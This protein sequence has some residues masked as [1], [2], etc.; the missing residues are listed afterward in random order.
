MTIKSLTRV[1]LVAV[2]GLL[3]ATLP[4]ATT[5]TVRQA[6]IEKEGIELI[7][8]IEGVA[9]GVHYNTDALRAHA[10]NKMSKWT[11]NHHLSEIRLLINDGLR[12][13]LTRL[14]EI[15]AELPEWKQKSIDTMLVS[16]RALAADTN[17]AILKVNE[18]G[19]KPIVL[20]DEYRALL[21][22]MDEH[23][24]NLVR[25]ADAA[26]DYAAAHHQATEAGLEVPKHR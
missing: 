24:E 7:N 19:S 25:T 8:Q 5:T 1:S 15:Q 12:P 22:T 9:R 13:A 2:L 20:N 4:A 3:P 18:N 21:D 23:A 11:H 17:S 16:A 6:A 26:A 10:R 14:A